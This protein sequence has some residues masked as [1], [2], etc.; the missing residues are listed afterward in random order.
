M[1]GNRVLKVTPL[2]GFRRGDRDA[3]VKVSISWAWKGD[4]TSTHAALACAKNINPRRPV[5]FVN[6]QD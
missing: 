6:R 1:L 2:S 4:A 3:L 5:F